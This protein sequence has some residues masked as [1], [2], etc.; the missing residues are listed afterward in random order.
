MYQSDKGYL[1]FTVDTF[2]LPGV[3]TIP[4]GAVVGTIV[5]TS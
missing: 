2:T 4:W 5:R 3:A 1:D